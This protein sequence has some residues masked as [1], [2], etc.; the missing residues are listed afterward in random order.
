MEKHTMQNMPATHKMGYGKLLWMAVISYVI[1]FILMY[2]MVDRMENVIVNMN[3]FYMAGLMTAPMVIIE[4]IIMGAMYKNKRLN[5]LIIF[6]SVVVLA[7][8]FLFIRNQTGVSDKQFLKSMIPHHAAAVLMVKET[9]IK[10]PEI[11]KLAD[12]II[13]SQQREIDF[14]KAKLRS[15]ESK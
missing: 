6:I 9:Q 14:M 15:M 1:M 4:I 12:D 13:S 7:G 10:D 11:K 5:T 3:Q 8:C 2:A